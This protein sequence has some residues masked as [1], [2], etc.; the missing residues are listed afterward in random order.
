VKSALDQPSLVLFQPDIP[1]NAG[2]LI[3]LSAC[4]NVRLDVIEPCGF[5]WDERRMRRAGMDYVDHAHVTRHRSYDAFMADH[6]AHVHG[7]LIL[8]TTL[9]ETSLDQ[10]RFLPHDR[11]MLG[12]ESAGVPA[13]VAARA[14]VR[15]RIPMADGGRSVNVAQSA[16]LALGAMFSQLA[17]WPKENR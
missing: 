6:S 13:E 16:T 4:M 17:L 9:G 12:R 10:F 14:D 15:M 1:Q 2:A 5:L 3:R 7:R 11:L 8:L